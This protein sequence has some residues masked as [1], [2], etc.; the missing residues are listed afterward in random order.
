MV[1]LY[2]SYIFLSKSQE[3]KPLKKLKKTES[4]KR[5]YELKLQKNIDSYIEEIFGKP[6]EADNDN[7][8]FKTKYVYKIKN[9]QTIHDVFF[10]IIEVVDRI[11]LEICLSEKTT[12]R[13]IRALEYIHEQITNSEI[14]KRY[15]T[16]ISYDA[17]SEY[18]C[19]KAYPELNKLER[20]LRKLLLNTYTINFG[21]EYYQT[22][23]NQELQT[24]V[25]TV[26]QAKGNEKKE[27]LKDLRNFFIQWNF[28]ILK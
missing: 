14:E 23:L 12:C 27:K 13:A 17:I 25:K 2:N 28:L 11:Y 21:T 16:I 24:R 5:V 4:N 6:I 8:C 10:T 20:N 15:I 3:E 1:T 22:T 19:N 26:I 18:Y 7:R 9:N